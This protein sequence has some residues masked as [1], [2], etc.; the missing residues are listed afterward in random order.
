MG[1][2]K[3]SQLTNEGGGLAAGAASNLSACISGRAGRLRPGG[4]ARCRGGAAE[5]LV[6]LDKVALRAELL[7]QLPRLG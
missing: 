5:Q 2:A 7:E 4:L 1:L 6:Q 3:L